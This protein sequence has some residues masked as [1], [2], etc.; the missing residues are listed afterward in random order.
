MVV[1]VFEVSIFELMDRYWEIGELVV[2]CLQNEVKP[3]AAKNEAV[4]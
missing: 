2:K 1:L 4:L 3:D